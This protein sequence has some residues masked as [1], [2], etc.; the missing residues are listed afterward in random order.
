MTDTVR[1]EI[2]DECKRDRDRWRRQALAHKSEA[3]HLAIRLA[4]ANRLL[5][6][7][8]RQAARRRELDEMF[9]V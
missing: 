2:Y 5:V 1:R 4:E 6:E 9:A 3:A 7:V 8:Q